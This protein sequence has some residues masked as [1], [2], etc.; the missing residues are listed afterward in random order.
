MCSLSYKTVVSHVIGILF[1]PTMLS[2]NQGSYK[3]PWTPENSGK[4]CE[5]SFVKRYYQKG[6]E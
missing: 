2:R 1:S 3:T 5:T 6:R 4:V